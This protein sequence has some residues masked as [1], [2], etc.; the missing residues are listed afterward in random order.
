MSYKTKHCG[1]ESAVW[2]CNYEERLSYKGIMQEGLYINKSVLLDFF[3]LN[4]MLQTK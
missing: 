2:M 1:A 3:L 4:K